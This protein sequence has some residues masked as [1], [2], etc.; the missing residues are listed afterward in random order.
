M[1]LEEL[2]ENAKKEI[3]K[4]TN[5][6]KTPGQ[7]SN[8]DS[9]QRNS[10]MVI[11]QSMM[12]A[13]N[14]IKRLVASTLN[15]HPEKLFSDMCETR[16]EILI[17]IPCEKNKTDKKKYTLSLDIVDKDYMLDL[18]PLGEF[19]DSVMIKDKIV[20]LLNT[21]KV[22]YCPIK[23]TMKEKLKDDDKSFNYVLQ[24]GL[25]T[26]LFIDKDSEKRIGVILKRV[27]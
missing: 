21:V 6:S 14:V 19:K 8:P 4:L 10:K 24:I 23:D 5:K 15:T 1:S 16:G 11:E 20:F 7:S 17:E 13:D 18:S 2:I 25:N 27:L 22:V 9:L 3:S 26:T 12:F